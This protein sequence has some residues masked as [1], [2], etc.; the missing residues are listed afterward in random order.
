MRP[1]CTRTPGLLQ[2]GFLAFLTTTATAAVASASTVTTVAAAPASAR[3]GLSTAGGSFSRAAES[4]FFDLIERGRESER[5]TSSRLMVR[6]V[7][8]F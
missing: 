1:P 3:T 2:R 4:A 5:G 6:D 8:C 7:E